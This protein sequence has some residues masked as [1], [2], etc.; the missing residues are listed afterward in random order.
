MENTFSGEIGGKYPNI[1][2]TADDFSSV[3]KA[4]VDSLKEIIDEIESLISE[5]QALSEIFIKECD[6]MKREINNFLLESSP[7]NNLD[8]SEFAKERADLRKKQIEISEI[9]LNE[10]VG[11][12]RDIAELKKEL[13]D[14]EK[15]LY[16]KESRAE[17]I[18]KILEE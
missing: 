17:E 16:E 6:K 15:E 10:K 9:Q 11:C 14:R 18:K 1:W 2:K 5:R 7:K 13:R 3:G 4:R 12:W 8:L